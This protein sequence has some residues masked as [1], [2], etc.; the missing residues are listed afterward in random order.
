MAR[1]QTRPWVKIIFLVWLVPFTSFFSFLVSF[2]RGE[3]TL[4]LIFNAD[5]AYSAIQD[6]LNLGNR[7]PGTTA[8]EDCANYFKE[9]LAPYTTVIDHNY[10]LHGTACQN[11]VGILNPT[12]SGNIVIIGAHYD[13]RAISE[14]DP[15]SPASPCPG[16]N[17]GAAGSAVLLELTRILYQIRQIL[18]VQIW[19]VFFD[20]EDQGYG[21]LSGWNYAEG[22]QVFASHLETILGLTPLSEVKLMLL[23]DMVGGTGLRFAKDGYSN[24]TIQD[25]F[26]Q[27]GRDLGYTSAFPTDPHYFSNLLDDH[28]WFAARGIPSVDFIIDFTDTSGPWPYHHTTGDNL[29]H[30]NTD[31][32]TITG[33]T[34]ERF[35]HE[36][37]V[38][39]VDGGGGRDAFWNWSGDWLLT[40]TGAILLSCVF[41][42][43]VVFGI[44]C[45]FKAYILKKHQVIKDLTTIKEASL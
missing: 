17:D 10:T 23:L 39:A 2:A 41:G 36:Y 21:G 11:V 24:S 42:A 28:K 38:S 13:S 14:K 6:Q 35:F 22:S 8:R 4:P 7:I 45:A 20:A 44:Y 30:I 40:E 3:S 12:V 34:L 43:C 29:T 1:V 31:S 19:F 27:L 15:I 32:L 25:L 37:Y 33:R 5:N 16:A 9:K 18:R 26:F